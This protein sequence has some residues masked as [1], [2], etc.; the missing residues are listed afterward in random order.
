MVKSF[1]AASSIQAA[2]QSRAA[3]AAT[4]AV[5]EWGFLVGQTGTSNNKDYVLGTVPATKSEAVTSDD[6]VD[7][8]IQV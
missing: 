8:A 2:F 1:V 6:L 4:T 7:Q 5:V 3:D